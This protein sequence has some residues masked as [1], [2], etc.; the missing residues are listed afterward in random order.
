MIKKFFMAIEVASIAGTVMM[1]SDYM[2]ISNDWDLAK[3]DYL[4]ETDPNEIQRKFTIY[5]SF[6][7]NKTEKLM[8][9]VGLGSA[10]IAVWI[11]NVLDVR[12]AIPREL[13]IPK[14]SKLKFGFNTSG[15]L[16][17]QLEF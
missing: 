8:G 12:Y 4:A 10:A 7:K 13:P 2:N 3:A 16:G 9:S 5:E 6:D 15:E 17:V 1:A 14:D 11:W